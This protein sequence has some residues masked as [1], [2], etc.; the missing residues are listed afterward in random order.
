MIR[1]HR[2]F[3]CYLGLRG[4]LRHR[5]VE[6]GWGSSH[7][8]VA[9]IVAAPLRITTECADQDQWRA[10]FGSREYAVI[11]TAAGPEGP[12]ILLI[13]IYAV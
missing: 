7:P 10:I 2:I 11:N 1:T 13:I 5:K 6:L 4:A 12:M 9:H 3:P 8:P